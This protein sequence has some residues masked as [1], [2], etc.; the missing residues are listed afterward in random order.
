MTPFYAIRRHSVLPYVMPRHPRPRDM[1]ARKNELVQRLDILLKWVNIGEESALETVKWTRLLILEWAEVT[2]LRF[3]NQKSTGGTLRT[4]RKSYQ[5]SPRSVV[6][7]WL[8]PLDKVHLC[9]EFENIL[10]NCSYLIFSLS[11]SLTHSVS[12]GVPVNL[13]NYKP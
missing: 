8:Q 3:L 12:T 1:L 13:I 9:W 2:S 11:I 6:L 7:D 4:D 10:Q 5:R